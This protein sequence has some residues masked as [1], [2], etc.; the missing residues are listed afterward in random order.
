MK[1]PPGENRS[2]LIA[3]FGPPPMNKNQQMPPPMIMDVAELE[4]TLLE[5][6]IAKNKIEKITGITRAFIT[7]FNNKIISIQRK[8][9]DIKEELFKDKPDLGKIRKSISEKTKLFSEIEFAQIKRDLEIKSELTR[10]EFDKLKSL[11][12]KKFREMMPED[13]RKNKPHHPM[14]KQPPVAN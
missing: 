10:E 12:K 6:G 4:S 2:P 3:P 5:I 11:T 1:D 9:L 8:E 14:N 7:G 13:M